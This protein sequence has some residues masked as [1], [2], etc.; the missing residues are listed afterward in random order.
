MVVYFSLCP[1]SSLYFLVIAKLK[2]VKQMKP[3]Q[4]LMT[5]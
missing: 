1:S 3:I 4:T 2:H 5:R